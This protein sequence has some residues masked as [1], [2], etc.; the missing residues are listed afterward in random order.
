MKN[1][2]YLTAFLFLT[3]LYLS[4]CEF[5]I[6]DENTT[7]EVPDATISGQIVESISGDPI[8][9]ATVKITDGI[10]QVNTTTGNDGAFFCK[11]PSF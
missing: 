11:L 4:G 3:G 9:N 5:G 7:P 8:F 6:P 10:T 1:I 2:I